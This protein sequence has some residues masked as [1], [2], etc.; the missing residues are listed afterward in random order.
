MYIIQHES[1][2]LNIKIQKHIEL[3]I[4][5]S[6]GNSFDM[7]TKIFSNNKSNITDTR[8]DCKPKME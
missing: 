2:R 3:Y 7:H 6:A 4:N 8:N 1:T 5:S